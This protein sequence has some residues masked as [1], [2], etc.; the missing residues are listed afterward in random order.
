VSKGQNTNHRLRLDERVGY[1]FSNISKRLHQALADAHVKKYR[2]SVSNWSLISVIAFFEPLSATELGKYT[3]LEPDKIARAT[4][5]L[6]RLGYVIRRQDERD[7]RKVSLSLSAEGRRVHDK[8]ELV[9]SQLEEEF[10]QVLTPKEQETLSTALT[11]L[12]RHSLV[13]FGKREGWF[14]R[15]TIS[16]LRPRG[17]KARSANAKLAGRLE[18]P[19]ATIR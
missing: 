1:R 2:L 17:V 3:S 7:R 9:A 10:L 8:I 15:R 13:L 6:V 5:T 11:K 16:G 19:Q 18:R 14:E 4:D 12:E